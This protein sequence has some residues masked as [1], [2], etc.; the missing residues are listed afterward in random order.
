MILFF[1][2]RTGK[3]A[4]RLLPGLACPFCGQ[5]DTLEA[6]VLPHFVHLFWIPVYRLRPMRWVACRHCKKQ[7]E[8][9]ELTPGMEAGLEALD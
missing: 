7:F 2:T 8:G 6:T 9:R 3:P 5:H 4:T 1:G